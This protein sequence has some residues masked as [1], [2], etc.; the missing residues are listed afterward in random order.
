MRVLILFLVLAFPAYC[1]GAGCDANA[2][3]LLH[4][5]GTDESTT[6]TEED[7]PGDGAYTMTAIGT[8]QIDTA[9]SKFG[10]A[11][12]LFDGDSDGLDTGD[13]SDFAWMHGKDDTSSFTFTIDGW[14]KLTSSSSGALQP[15]F[16]TGEYS[17]AIIGMGLYLRDDIWTNGLTMIITRGVNGQPVLDSAEC[18]SGISDTNWHHIEVSYDQSL[19]SAN[20]E[21]FVDGTSKCTHNKTAYTPSTSNSQ[22]NMHVAIYPTEASYFWDGWIDEFRISDNVRHTDNFTAPTEAY[23][24]ASAGQVI[25]ITKK[26][27]VPVKVG[28]GYDRI[29]T[30][31]IQNFG[32]NGIEVQLA[33]TK[34]R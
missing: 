17:S 9:Q 3:V 7:C 32:W 11:S 10:G 24:V 12:G 5:D 2:I 4:M 13:T 30:Q 14:F 6:F 16:T 26:E 23:S 8:A 33:K 18:A 20:A 28:K 25:I 27:F 22:Y 29:I 15:I 19:A 31:W 21:Y 34:N 1:Y